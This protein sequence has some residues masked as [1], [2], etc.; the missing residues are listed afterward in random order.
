MSVH[1]IVRDFKKALEYLLR[2]NFNFKI[3]H[4]S[5]FEGDQSKI[6][7]LSNFRIEL[8]CT[9]ELLKL[10]VTVQKSYLVSTPVST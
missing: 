2:T 5:I 3:H 7:W 6:I 1:K 9:A 8:R 4:G 10:F